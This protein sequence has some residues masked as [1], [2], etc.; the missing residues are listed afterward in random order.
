M[1]VLNM[2]DNED[3]SFFLKK[4]DN[5]RKINYERIGVI[6]RDTDAEIVIEP[7]ADI[8]A[9]LETVGVNDPLLFKKRSSRLGD[10][11]GEKEVVGA[12]SFVLIVVVYGKRGEWPERNSSISEADWVRGRR[13]TVDSSKK[14]PF[15][16]KKQNLKEKMSMSWKKRSETCTC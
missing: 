3:R 5:N 13:S 15:P 10:R 14:V 6:L 1:M 8:S 7:E 11:V 2:Y 4:N 9:N 12:I 16:V